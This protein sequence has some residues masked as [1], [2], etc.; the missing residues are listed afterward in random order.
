MELSQYIESWEQKLEKG[1]ERQ[2]P[3]ADLYGH[4]KAGKFTSEQVLE[5]YRQRDS[6][7]FIEMVKRYEQGKL[8]KAQMQSWE[9]WAHFD[10]IEDDKAIAE[11]YLALEDAAQMR[12]AEGTPNSI[13]LFIMTRIH[14]T[15]PR[16][17]DSEKYVEHLKK[18]WISQNEKL[19][20]RWNP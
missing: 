2:F 11:K 20:W 5:F 7:H 9:S 3:L 8:F 1:H 19:N 16:S 14:G 10:Y 12:K 13:R 15:R 6:P 17:N 4:F 18:V